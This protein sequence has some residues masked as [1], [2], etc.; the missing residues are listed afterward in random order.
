MFLND[1]APSQSTQQPKSR[2]QLEFEK[3]LNNVETEMAILCEKVSGKFAH[4]VDK[5]EHTLSR[6]GLEASPEVKHV[7]HVKLHCGKRSPLVVL[8]SHADLQ[9]FIQRCWDNDTFIPAVAPLPPEELTHGPEMDY[10]LR[11]R[12]FNIFKRGLRQQRQI[13][14]RQRRGTAYQRFVNGSRRIFQQ[15]ALPRH[16]F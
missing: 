15:H 12:L 11:K 13:R 14:R 4:M 2:E 9:T 6:R 1:D 16:A 3:F 7:Y 10:E 5:F 8:E